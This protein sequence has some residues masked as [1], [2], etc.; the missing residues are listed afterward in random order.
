MKDLDQ[1]FTNQ[2]V[3]D[4]NKWDAVRTN[5]Q[6]VKGEI[7]ENENAISEAE[8]AIIERATITHGTAAPAAGATVDIHID[9]TAGRVYFRYSD[10]NYHYAALT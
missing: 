4:N 5:F 6:I 3:P 9:E 7:E 1:N 10:G 8:E 2:N